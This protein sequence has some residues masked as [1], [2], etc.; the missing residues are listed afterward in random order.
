MD[1]EQGAE[2]SE[3]WVVGSDPYEVLL[4]SSFDCISTSDLAHQ[5]VDLAGGAFP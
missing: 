4:L 3:Q 1:S 5:F 2:L